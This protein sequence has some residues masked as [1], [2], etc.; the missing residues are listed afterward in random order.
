[1]N[2]VG[3]RLLL[4]LCLCLSALAASAQTPAQ[5]EE[6]MNNIKLDETYIFGEGSDADKNEA[7]QRALVDLLQIVNELRVGQKKEPLAQ[8]DIQPRVEELTY[9]QGGITYTMLYINADKALALVPKKS[10][11]G[12]NHGGNGQNATTPAATPVATSAAIPAVTPAAS[13]A[14]IPA[15]TPVVTPV[16]TPAVTPA[17]TPAATSQSVQDITD[18]VK[19][20]HTWIEVKGTLQQHVMERRIK[21]GKASSLSEVPEDA[22]ALLLNSYGDIVA[23]LSPS[24]A[25]QRTDLKTN[26]IYSESNSPNYSQIFWYK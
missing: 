12:G 20:L 7:Y 14:V 22:V 8:R 25:Q 13:P 11:G 10:D 17:A 24:N 6:K 1:M 15:A 19:K 18:Y 21:A 5:I 2:K 23:V 9:T 16:A 4:A 26:K 3:L